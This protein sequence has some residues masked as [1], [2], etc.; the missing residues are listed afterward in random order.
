MIYGHGDDIFNFTTAIRYNFSTNIRQDIDLAPL[1]DFLRSNI[2]AVSSYPE[3]LGDSLAGVI[4]NNYNI[5]PESVLITN[6]TAEAIYLL[7]QLFNGSKSAICIP[8]FSEYE[9]ACA[10]FGHSISFLSRYEF[11]N[12]GLSGNNLIWLC[13]P[14]NPTGELI[15][16]NTLNNLIFKNPDYYFIID[17]A[18]SEFTAER[19]SQFNNI[20][21]FRNLIILKSLTKA[22]GIPGLRLGFIAADKGIIRSLKNI[23]QPWSVN[24][25]AI[26]TGKFIYRNMSLFAKPILPLIK[27]RMRLETVL[28]NRFSFKIIPSQT[29]F[30]TAELPH[31]TASGLKDLLVNKNGILIRDASNFRGLGKRHIRLAAVSQEADD[32]LIQALEGWLCR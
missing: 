12:G 21:R 26:E 25:L 24:S 23:K 5:E 28:Q 30:F 19:A 9:S 10:I 7:A 20:T 3:P 14:N 13:N 2:H 15:P 16:Q 8:T 31:G 18:Y 6:G 32:M 17:E 4:A 22:Y 1:Y 29:T 27:E 11:I